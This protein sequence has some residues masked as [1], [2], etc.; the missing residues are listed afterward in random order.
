MKS[1]LAAALL[2]LFS[3]SAFAGSISVAPVQV[4]SRG[5]PRVSVIH[6]D[7]AG[8]QP[9]RY[10]IEVLAWT[11]RDGKNVYAP[12]HDLLVSP[13]MLEL[14]AKAK[15]I[16]RVLPARPLTGP[17]Y[18]VLFFRQLSS[19][20]AVKSKGRVVNL[21]ISQALKA[22]YEP[23]N[24]RPA[25]LSARVVDGHL[26]IANSGGSHAAIYSIGHPNEKPVEAG[27]L[28]WVLPG[29]AFKFNAPAKAGETF[30]IG[31]ADHKTV[32]LVAQ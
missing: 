18:Y 32:T 22:S 7:N 23:S 28:G 15:R 1:F 2:A 21:L 12:S 26:E 11:Q 29:G 3:A 24:A 8:D 20:E 14:P 9:T 17:H 31:L 10:Q 6:F 27:A 25:E 13:P 16:V 30:V 4:L 5:T 19:V